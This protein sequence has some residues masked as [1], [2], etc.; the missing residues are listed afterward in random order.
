MRTFRPTLLVA[1]VPWW[2]EMGGAVN[3][4]AR[5]M[6]TAMSYGSRALPAPRG[7]SFHIGCACTSSSI[8]C[9]RDFGPLTWLLNTKNSAPA[10]TESALTQCPAVNSTCGDTTAAVQADAVGAPGTLAT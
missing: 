7:K 3:V 8:S 9:G 5:T 10:P 2:Y 6:P 4:V 1:S